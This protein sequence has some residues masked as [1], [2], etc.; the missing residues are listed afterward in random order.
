MA[1]TKRWNPSCSESLTDQ[2][3]SFFSGNFLKICSPLIT[4]HG[5]GY[6][7]CSRD[8]EQKKRY[9][10]TISADAGW[11]GYTSLRWLL[12]TVTI[13][14]PFSGSNTQRDKTLI[15]C[16]ILHPLWNYLQWRNC[17]TV[18]SQKHFHGGTALASSSQKK[19]LLAKSILHAESYLIKPPIMK[20]ANHSGE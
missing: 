7:Q 14:C 9:Q 18:S 17:K 20:F 10:F 8:T 1:I 3:H 19:K 15:V 2:P 12:S 11:R 13:H 4:E 5:F 6:W 16:F